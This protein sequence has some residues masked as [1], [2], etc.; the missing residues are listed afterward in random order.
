MNFFRK[1]SAGLLQ[2]MWIGLILIGAPQSGF[3]ASGK[4]EFL[5]DLEAYYNSFQPTADSRLRHTLDE[6]FKNKVFSGFDIPEATFEFLVTKYETISKTD[7]NFYAFSGRLP[8]RFASKAPASAWL[9]I[10]EDRFTFIQ[11]IPNATAIVRESRNAMATAHSLQTLTMDLAYTQSKSQISLSVSEK[12]RFQELLAPYWKQGLSLESPGLYSSFWRWFP[13]EQALFTSSVLG[14]PEALVH[15]RLYIRAFI[16]APRDAIHLESF[17]RAAVLSAFVFQKSVPEASEITELLK[18]ITTNT[19]VS[20]RIR[21][22]INDLLDPKTFRC[23][24]SL[25]SE[26]D[27]HSFSWLASKFQI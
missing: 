2:V 21:K 6:Q 22:G 24:K 17:F 4:E 20:E 13:P 1:Q 16:Q 7:P 12:L 8:T 25:V 5:R 26:A 11:N 19:N 9:H 3:A 23:A 15:A 27:S 14:D 10:L 18:S